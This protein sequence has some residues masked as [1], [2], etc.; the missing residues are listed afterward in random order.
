VRLRTDS[1]VSTGSWDVVVSTTGD[2]DGAEATTTAEDILDF[3]I[4]SVGVF[5]NR[6]I[7]ALAPIKIQLIKI[8]IVR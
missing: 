8:E 1:E 4:Y 6:K 3:L 5:L 2:W 7:N